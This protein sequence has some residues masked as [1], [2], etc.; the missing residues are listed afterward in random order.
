[1]AARDGHGNV[2]P[3]VGLE[4]GHSVL[5][6]GSGAR[7]RV[8]LELRRAGLLEEGNGL[9]SAI[10]LNFTGNILSKKNSGTILCQRPLTM[11]GWL[12]PGFGEVVGSGDTAAAR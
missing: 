2:V 3:E 9:L 8:S 12:T 1:M 10:T 6:G 7:C 4:G 5:E 11:W